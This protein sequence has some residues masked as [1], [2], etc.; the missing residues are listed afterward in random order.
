MRIP[1]RFQT[2]LDQD[3]SL[4]GIVKSVVSLYSHFLVEHNI[5]F[6][7]E[8]TNHGITHIE[9]ILIAAD[10]LMPDDTFNH[11]LK[12]IDVS[13]LILCA[14]LHDSG[15]H[16]NI[17]LFAELVDKDNQNILVKDIDDK[18]WPTLWNDYLE[19]VKKY[20]GKQKKNLFGNEYQPFK[21]P[22]LHDKLSIDKAD[23]MLIGEFI[24]RYHPRLAHEMSLYGIKYR[25][26]V[27]FKLPDSISTNHKDLVG[28]ISR[29]HGMN[30]RDTFS[31]LSNKYDDEWAQPYNIHVIYL[32]ALLRISDYFQIDASRT[33][34]LMLKIKSFDSPFSEFEHNKHLSIDFVKTSTKDP[35]TY[36]VQANPQ[37]S[38]MF[39]KLT[40]LFKD[41][42]YELDT[43]WAVLGEIYGKDRVSKQ[44]K[45]KYRRIK[46]NLDKDGIFVKNISYVPEK[47]S[48]DTDPD[49]PKLLISPLY[50]S[51]PTYGVRE[52]IQN[53]VDACSER[54][55]LEKDCEPI[56]RASIE[57]ID[58]QIFFIIRDNGKGMSLYEIKNYFLKVG[59]SFR[60]SL[61]WAKNFTDNDGLPRVLRNGR[62]GIGVLA[63]FLLGDKIR[64]ITRSI[65]DKHGYRFDASVDDNQIEVFKD[66]DCDYG[67]T[68]K[69]QID[70][71]TA[72]SLVESSYIDNLRIPAWDSWFVFNKP[73]ILYKKS[74]QNI[75][76]DWY[77]KSLLN[78]TE[79]KDFENWNTFKIEAIDKIL[80][81]YDQFELKRILR[82]KDV[83]VCN[84]III[85]EPYVIHHE[86][87]K[88]APSVIVYDS[89]GELNL[90]LSRNKI[91]GEAIYEKK[92]IKEIYKQIIAE[93]LMLDTFHNYKS[94][95]FFRKARRAY[96]HPAFSESYQTSLNSFKID[97]NPIP[98][99]YS[100]DG[101]CLFHEFFINKLVG[102]TIIEVMLNEKQ[103]NGHF[104]DWNK[105]ESDQYLFL[106]KDGGFDNGMRINYLIE[107]LN[108]APNTVSLQPAS[109]I[110][111]I[112]SYYYHTI[113]ES[114]NKTKK[115]VI[116]T[117]KRLC[118]DQEWVIYS[119]KYDHDFSNL[120]NIDFLKGQ[121]VYIKQSQLALVETE[122]A[123]FNTILEKHFGNN[124]VI[125][126][127]INDRKKIFK[128]AFDDL[129]PFMNNIK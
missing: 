6:F 103:G 20:S 110:V 83:T 76:E 99:I 120:L 118:Y 9:E 19:E 63:V 46:S 127:D 21:K 51:K 52:L 122:H 39:I 116:K 65:F 38:L 27:F 106:L 2:K 95:R 94:N 77:Q 125:P 61:E 32:M 113:F 126:Y 1:S 37:T 75:Y 50:G 123:L 26:K 108:N 92:L 4:D 35:E 67:T 85:P 30:L 114:S 56:I 44:P 84:G 48:F 22:T 45:L 24:R 5:E 36:R 55:Y 98:L 81:S 68:I 43:S 112:K 101:F 102:K 62:F 73:L 87:I 78:F 8:Y 23:R 59:S 47:I 12:P 104:F 3:Q 49:L 128:Y 25:G 18:A 93:V 96:Y 115:S 100:K 71:D 72:Q 66:N 60:R 105:A 34:T 119:Y 33:D 29:S 16:L 13:I 69:V 86:A 42:Q 58:E 54:Q 53:S 90:N 15:M 89:R 64:V 70:V 31:Y 79:G 17:D 11:V 14:V 28:L 107:N 88:S 91:D 111:A 97:S 10:D 82:S 117:H 40:E 121:S 80:W 7:P 41:I 57:E 109:E 129:E 74:F 124:I